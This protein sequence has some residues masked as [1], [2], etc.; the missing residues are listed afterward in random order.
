MAEKKICPRCGGRNMKKKHLDD[1]SYI[2]VCGVC[3]EKRG[4]LKKDTK[5]GIV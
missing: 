4:P 5:I 1:G 3:D 2:L